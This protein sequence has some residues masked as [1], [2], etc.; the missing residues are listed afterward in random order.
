MKTLQ[1]YFKAIAWLLTGLICFQSCT[2]YRSTGVSIDEAVKSG[3]K[4]KVVTSHNKTIRFKYITEENGNYFGIQKLK[5]EYV[6]IPVNPDRTQLIRP[7][8]KT[9]SFI[10]SVGGPL[11]IIGG[12]LLADFS[13]T[14]R[15]Y[16][17]PIIL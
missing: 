17:P 14:E 3:D 15:S 9:V 8:N 10:A 6:K 13:P 7:I 1:H 12:V 2:I 16:A 4:V 11:L 5:G